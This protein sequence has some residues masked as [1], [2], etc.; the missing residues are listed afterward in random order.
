[1]K[2]K[3][4]F[5]LALVLLISSTSFGQKKTYTVNEAKE[6]N[7]FNDFK[8]YIVTH[9]NQKA[10]IL[11]SNHLEYMLQKFFFIN[12]KADSLNRGQIINLNKIKPEKMLYLK[13]SISDFFNYFVERENEKVAEN[14]TAMPIRI[15]KDT[16]IFNRLTSFQK[17][18]SLVF[19]DKRNPNKTLGYL[20][21]IPPIKG[22]NT[23]TKIW[24]WKLGFMFGKFFF[25]SL[26]GEEGYEYMFSDE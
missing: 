12:L 18:N 1:M 16:F 2:Q 13:K 25:T 10:D 21:F 24:S 9:I 20:L 14:I 7:L 3:R 22:V 8:N 5:I 6:I 15:S 23:E 19:F 26:D 11:D 4:N 17:E